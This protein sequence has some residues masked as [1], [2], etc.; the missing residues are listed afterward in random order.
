MPRFPIHR[1]VLSTLLATAAGSAAASPQALSNDAFAQQVRGLRAA[2]T[3]DPAVAEQAALLC[4]H[5]PPHRSADE[6]RCVALKAHLRTTRVAQ[7]PAVAP[8][9]PPTPPATDLMA[10]TRAAVLGALDGMAARLRGTA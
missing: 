10:C 8:P 9:V 3:A 4:T 5:L 6:P 7:A 2:M 1:L